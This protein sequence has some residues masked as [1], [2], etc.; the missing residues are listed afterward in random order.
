MA[1]QSTTAASLATADATT[2]LPSRVSVVAD[3]L[4]RTAHLESQTA[5]AVEEGVRSRRHL[6]LQG[7]AQ[8]GAPAASVPL[9]V[10]GRRAIGRHSLSAAR[11]DRTA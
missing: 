7:S 6:L 2:A 3:A 5:T 8:G 1:S 4:T 10:A 9:G 11:R